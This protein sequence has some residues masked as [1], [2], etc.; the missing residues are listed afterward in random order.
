[1][2]QLSHSSGIPSESLSAITRSSPSWTQEQP[3]SPTDAPASVP[4][5]MSVQS[6][7]PS[8]STSS[9]A[10]S[11]VHSSVPEV[12]SKVPVAQSSASIALS[13]ASLVNLCL[14]GFR[15]P[16]LLRQ[17]DVPV[18]FELGDLL[19]VLV[20]DVSQTANE[21]RSDHGGKQREHHD[22][23]SW[24]TG[25]VRRS[26]R[27]DRGAAPCHAAPEMTEIVPPMPDRDGNRKQRES[28]R[29]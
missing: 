26:A 28:E 9:R 27:C 1:M 4:G 10:S 21:E 5:Q 13:Q 29:D 3:V 15:S 17:P 18:R 23:A 20:S 2:G 25:Q 14:W 16:A 8:A 11:S 19:L 22:S 12:Q 24:I 6:E 7:T